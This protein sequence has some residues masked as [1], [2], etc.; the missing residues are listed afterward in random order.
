MFYYNGACAYSRQRKYNEAVGFRKKC[1][2]LDSEY[3]FAYNYLGYDLLMLGRL[4]EALEYFEKAIELCESSPYPYRNKFDTLIRLKRYDEALKFGKEN[5][6]QFTISYLGK[7]EFLKNGYYDA[8][9]DM[10]LKETPNYYAASITVSG[11]QSNI[12]LY[13][14]QERAIGEIPERD[15]FAGLLVL[16]TG[17]GKTIT[18]CYWLMKNILNKGGK[19][20]W[21][22][23][24]QILLN[25]AA[26]AFEK[27][28]YGNIA[29]EGK[30]FKRRIISGIHDIPANIDKNDDFLI[31]I[32]DSLRPD[33][34]LKFFV[35]N[36]L[37]PNSDKVVLVIDEAHHAAAAEYTNIINIVKSYANSFK[38]LGL[39]ATPYRTK[40]EEQTALENLFPDGIIGDVSLA[41]LISKG[42][43]AM[44]CFKYVNS[45]GMPQEQIN[46]II[47]KHYIENKEEYGQ[48]IVFAKSVD[49]AIE[50]DSLF[51]ET[52]KVKSMCAASKFNNSDAVGNAFRLK[53][54]DVVVNYDIFTEGA[55]FPEAKTVFIARPTINKRLM[56]QMVGRALRGTQSGGAEKAY[57]VTFADKNNTD[58][59]LPHEL[60]TD[61]DL[62]ECK[63]ESP[64]KSEKNKPLA[65]APVIEYESIDYTKLDLGEIRKRNYDLW[66]WLTDE[67]YRKY[68]KG[69]YYYSALSGFKSKNRND[70][71]ID[72]I[73]PR[74]E[75][76]LTRLDNLQLLTKEENR[77]K[78][79]KYE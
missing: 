2:E 66:L 74:K 71:E 33:K 70:F 48:T 6:N 5:Q 45:E 16:P 30:V 77:R 23:D 76:G 32:I 1:L 26:D 11:K 42:I 58:L 68:Y 62:C 64:V 10:L 57:I 56:T 18:A 50:I 21:L 27:V 75:G 53:K 17:A 41:E 13:D 78:S 46:E 43:L 12:E 63:P 22:A 49:D 4:E 36:W 3:T 55:D 54:T 72:H 28:C 73:K 25:Q 14:H 19:V 65:E 44:P 35:N 59:I 61:S 60:C 38:M 20:I 31:S 7:L 69:G 47:A 52:G 67:V 39:T 15:S 51:N 9:Q 24:R 8:L 29:D 40:G 37:K 79:D 34:G